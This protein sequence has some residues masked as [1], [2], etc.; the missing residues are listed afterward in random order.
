MFTPP[1]VSL[2][3]SPFFRLAS[4]HLLYV[5]APSL[6]LSVCLLVSVN[7]TLTVSNWMIVCT[8][9][10]AVWMGQCVYLMRVCESRI[11]SLCSEGAA[12]CSMCVYNIW[13]LSDSLFFPPDFFFRVLPLLSCVKP[14]SKPAH[15]A[16]CCLCSPH[17]TLFLSHL[18][19]TKQRVFISKHS[20]GR[21]FEFLTRAIC[22]SYGVKEMKCWLRLRSWTFLDCLVHSLWKYS[23]M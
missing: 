20:T 23:Q 5:K 9:T 8:R 10:G 3:N 18:Y 19:W 7:N 15:S 21:I 22:Y 13:T 6:T 14:T 12:C 4:C 11:S 17:Q 2:P 1:P 16:Q